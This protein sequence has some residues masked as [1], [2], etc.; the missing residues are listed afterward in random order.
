M[1]VSTCKRARDTLASLVGVTKRKRERK[2]ERKEKKRRRKG[3]S[4]VEEEMES[5]APFS[6]QSV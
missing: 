2:E 1:N 6:L 5:A 4:R 3:K